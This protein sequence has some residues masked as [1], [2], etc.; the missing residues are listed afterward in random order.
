MT[1]LRNLETGAEIFLVG[2]AHV[3]ANSAEEVKEVIRRVKP[4][5]VMIELDPQR[6]KQLMSGDQQSGFSF[7]QTM[8]QKLT[9][10][11]RGSWAQMFAGAGMT[12]MYRMLR[13]A[14]LD[15]GA[16]FKAAILE[17]EN[18]G[19][20]I[21]Y[22]DQDQNTTMA[23]ISQHL[24]LQNLMRMLAASASD[25]AGMAELIKDDPLSKMS[26]VDR[27]EAM[28]TRIAVRKTLEAVRR[29]NPKLVE[30]LVDERDQ[31]MVDCLGKL[32]GTVVGVVGL[33]HLDGMERLWAQ[34]SG[35]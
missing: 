3:S 6:A 4:Q 27:V 19:A 26:L 22:G 18:I 13:V 10:G 35:A 16:E 33:G 2:T 20:R 28:K 21:V 25:S 7:A 17:A 15:P 12:A 34:R 14:G 31:I 1:L 11:G 23:R 8:I 32:E 29:L 9:G 24:G 30:A 5:T